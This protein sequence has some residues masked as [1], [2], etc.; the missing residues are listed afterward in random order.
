MKVLDMK[1]NYLKPAV[2]AHTIALQN[3][4]AASPDLDPE[5]GIGGD[6]STGED[7][8]IKDIEDISSD[9]FGGESFG[10]AEEW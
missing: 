10:G 2:Q 4:I 9:L 5:S 8:L 6:I 3:M 1:K 7:V